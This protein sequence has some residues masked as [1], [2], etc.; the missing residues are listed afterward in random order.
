MGTS[1]DKRTSGTNWGRGVRA[2]RAPNAQQILRVFGEMK[3]GKTHGT[4]SWVSR[5]NQI[6]KSFTFFHA[7]PGR[8][9]PGTPT[10]SI[11]L[12]R[13]RK[14]HR[15]L[16]A[17]TQLR[18]HARTKPQPKPKSISRLDCHPQPPIPYSENQRIKYRPAALQHPKVPFSWSPTWP[19]KALYGLI[20]PWP[21]GP[22]SPLW[23]LIDPS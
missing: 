16:R 17:C 1:E 7:G 12:A 2:T 4:L 14:D 3:P 10:T 18:T 19:F 23:P 13:P 9:G 15:P 11:F 21:W 6:L 22:Y 5:C 20:A 8:P